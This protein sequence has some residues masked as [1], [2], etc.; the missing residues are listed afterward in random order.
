MNMNCVGVRE[1]EE[2]TRMNGDKTEK[3]K[4]IR[5]ERP[6]IVWKVSYERGKE[7]EEVNGE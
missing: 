5:K 7:M 6:R 2:G 3:I 1:I 4:V